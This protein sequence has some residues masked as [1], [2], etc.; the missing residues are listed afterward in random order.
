[1]RHVLEHYR[2]A[3]NCLIAFLGAA[4]GSCKAYVL[5]LQHMWREVLTLHLEQC[6]V[7]LLPPVAAAAAVVIGKCK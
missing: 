6:H 3:G 2:T 5:Y 7:L 4:C 1:M